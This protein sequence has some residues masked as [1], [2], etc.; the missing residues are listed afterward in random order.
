MKKY[1]PIIIGAAIFGLSLFYWYELRPARIKHDCS[2]VKRTKEATPE[3]SAMT[4]EELKAKGLLRDCS[5]IKT[6][7]VT[8]FFDGIAAS[9]LKTFNKNRQSVCEDGNK[10][11]IED[12]KI[13]KPAESAEVWYEKAE[14][15][16]YKFCLRDKGL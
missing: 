4:E 3:R 2:W 16:E 5:N 9:N 14:D 1:F 11:I 7:V 8:E 6:D 13:S 15:E 12:Y 10:R